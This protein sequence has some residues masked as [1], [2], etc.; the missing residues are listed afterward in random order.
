MTFI[1]LVGEQRG[2]KVQ[3]SSKHLILMLWNFKTTFPD[4]KNKFR[5]L[6]KTLG[7]KQNK[8]KKASQTEEKHLKFLSKA[9]QLTR[10]IFTNFGCGDFF[11]EDFDILFL[12]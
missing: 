6:N 10:A 9:F 5:I 2:K 12:S 7:Q 3:K 4:L 8:Q 1:N 11:F